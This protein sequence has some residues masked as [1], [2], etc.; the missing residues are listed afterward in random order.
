LQEGEI[1]TSDGVQ[2]GKIEVVENQNKIHFSVGKLSLGF[3]KSSG[4]L[5]SLDVLGSEMLLKSPKPHYWRAP[6]DNDYGNK[7]HTRLKAWKEATENQ[8]LISFSH[9]K[10][11][12][13]A[14][15]RK[16]I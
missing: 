16:R 8:T 3:N 5:T 13:G 6:I 14:S 10:N 4:Y 2:N 1:E 7:M 9:K 12:K 11:K 15:C